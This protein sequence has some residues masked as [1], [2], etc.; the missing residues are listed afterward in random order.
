M[1]DIEFMT[2]FGGILMALLVANVTNNMADAHRARRDLPIGFVPWAISFYLVG[3]VANTYA[4]YDAVADVIVF[5]VVTIIIAMAT[6]LPY[7]FLSRFLYPEHP[8]KWGSV[9]DYYLSNRIFILGLL[10]IAPLIA[11]ANFFYTAAVPLSEVIFTVSVLYAPVIATQFLLMLTEK[12][13]WHWAGW[14]FLIIHRIGMLVWLAVA[15]A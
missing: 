7:I 2:S 4:I 15:T 5:D 10:A 13:Q 6:I 9:E 12:R 14:S 11:S 8:E 1:T 3:A